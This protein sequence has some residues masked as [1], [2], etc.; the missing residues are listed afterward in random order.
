MNS[1]LGNRIRTL[2]ENKHLSQEKIAEKI[3]ISKSAYK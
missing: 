2:R 3:G 1:K